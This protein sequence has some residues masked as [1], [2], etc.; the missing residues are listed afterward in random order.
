MYKKR[1]LLALCLMVAMT[2]SAQQEA[3][4]ASVSTSINGQTAVKAFDN[5]PT[6]AWSLTARDLSLP[7][8]MMLNLAASGDVREIR[9]EC[10]GVSA[11]KLSELL[12]IYVTYDP[13]NLGMPVEYKVA[14]SGKAFVLSMQPK[15]GAHVKLALKPGVTNKQLA[16]KEMDVYLAEMP[17]VAAAEDGGTRRYMDAKL[18]LEER[19]NSL[20]EVMTV[21]DKMELLR[22]GWGIP[23]IPHLGVPDMKKVE[24]LH[25]FSYGSGATI[26]PQSIA[27][28]ATW[29]KA[30]VEEVAATIGD[31]TVSAHAVQAWSPVLDVA[32]D[33]RWGR[34]EE[35]YGEDPVLV[36]QI[37][38]AWIKGYQSKGLITTPKH[39]GGHGAPLGGR[40]SHDI[41]LSERELR[42]V[43]LVP[44]A[45]V[46]TRVTEL[47]GFERIHLRPGETKTVRF[48]LTPYEISLL[49]DDMDR[50][51][52][53][54]ELKIMVGG[55]SPTYQ[56]KDKIKDSIG[57]KAD[58]E[59]VNATID[60]PYSFAADMNLRIE[61]VAQNLAD[62]GATVTVAVSNDGNLTDVDK[63]SLFVD[64][65]KSDTR[66]FELGPGQEK[67][68]RFIVD[69]PG[70]QS[71][72]LVTKYKMTE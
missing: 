17:V 52:E 72:R 34:C 32:Q 30:L 33:A 66:H 31:E 53:K 8:W 71:L 46:K 14:Q 22:E 19:V 11:G 56:A 47:K 51:V 67:R 6:T 63:V 58:S 9:M 23:G 12:D 39:F 28:G 16:L 70:F 57:F 40:D 26:F 7:Q 4:I 54:G 43:H 21:A 49:N 37:G 69:K 44:Y 27:L 62:G 3:G 18:P 13:M 36:T 25:G 59:G 61:E 38:G 20:L 64:G 29:N 15:Y 55:A 68:I 48:E 45:S 60:Y 50:V 42:E 24:A 65:E 35:T 1:A 5:D 41:G 10:D 2:A